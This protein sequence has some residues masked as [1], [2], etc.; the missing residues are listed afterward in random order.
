MRVTISL[1]LMATPMLCSNRVC[2]A[3]G[4]TNLASHGSD[5]SV[6]HAL[7][8]LWDAQITCLPVRLRDAAD[9]YGPRQRTP[10]AMGPQGVRR[11]RSAMEQ[12]PVRAEKVNRW[13]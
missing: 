10:P 12:G 3:L 9:S 8:G 2:V 1:A 7:Q 6:S 13:A 5:T 11:Q 4:N